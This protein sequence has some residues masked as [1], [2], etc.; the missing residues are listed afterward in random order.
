MEP[1]RYRNVPAGVTS[2]T[3]SKRASDDH[4][5]L[6]HA[7][8]GCSASGSFTRGRTKRSTTANT[9]REVNTRELDDDCGALHI[10]EEP[11]SVAHIIAN[12]CSEPSW[13]V[14]RPAGR[15]RERHAQRSAKTDLE[16][17]RP[18]TKVANLRPLRV[19]SAVGLNDLDEFWFP[20][21]TY[22]QDQTGYAQ[23]V[24]PVDHSRTSLIRN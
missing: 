21:Q 13:Q 9:W 19:A 1:L 15:E 8:P 18:R 2:E 6:E 11:L 16:F 14:V 23:F 24:T 22:P 5:G 4:V 12:R 20:E 17:S 10:R 3:H 7:H